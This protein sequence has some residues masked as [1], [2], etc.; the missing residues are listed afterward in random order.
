MKFT[1]FTVLLVFLLILPSFLN[2]NLIADA[3]TASTSPNIFLGVDVS[4]ESVP[5]TEKL[6]DK[7]SSY[8]NLF[9]IGCYGNYNLTRL[10]VISQYVYDKGLSFIVYTDSPRYPSSQWLADAKKTYGDNF[11][12]IYYLDEVGGKQLD[13]SSYPVV[14]NAINFNDAATRYVQIVNFL[15]RN[16]TYGVTR[17]FAYPDEFQLFTSDYS[18][19]WYDYAAGYDTVFA[20]FTMNYSQQLNL[21][22]VRGA[23]TSQN[24]DWG[25]MIT[26][27]YNLPPY[28]ESGSELL[29][30]MKLAYNNGAKYII[31]F[32]GDQ[33]WTQSVL[34]PGQLD[35]IKA[36]WEYAQSTPRTISPVSD[37]TAFVLPVD[38]AYGFRGPSDRIWGLWNPDSLTDSICRNVSK[39]M[40]EY[41]YNLDIV[42]PNG[43][44]P[45][46]SLGY[47]NVFYWNDPR[48][49]DVPMASATDSATASQKG[50]SLI[51]MY[52]F[53]GTAAILTIVAVATMFFKLKKR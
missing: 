41:G 48:L 40:Q 7:V 8:T 23:A 17:N 6:I 10:S 24:K 9:V 28:M 19:Y 39:L 4:F 14:T 12:G 3:A 51:E 38:Y 18:L 33:N 46:E 27:K 45:V 36:F 20:E 21:D 1:L 30:D 44:N 16:G 35:A 32:D 13:Q 25:V 42:Y 53:Y 49:A 43:T 26:W 11:L 34:K 37:R 31:V 22:L 50:F 47:R 29:N 5:A 2:Y 52:V 15:L